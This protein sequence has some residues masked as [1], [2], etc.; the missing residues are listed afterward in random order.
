MSFVKTQVGFSN[1]N[2]S[3]VGYHRCPWQFSFLFQQKPLVIY[4]GRKQNS[5]NTSSTFK[6]FIKI[7][8]YLTCLKCTNRGDIRKKLNLYIRFFLRSMHLIP[9]LSLCYIVSK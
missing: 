1:Q 5:D 6:T 3:V 4:K 8:N 2:M 7:T 9:S